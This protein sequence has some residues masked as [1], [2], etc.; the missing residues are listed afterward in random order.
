[1]I[2][3]NYNSPGEIKKTLTELGLSL[4][5]RWGQNFL[6]NRGA[7]KKIIA[8]INPQSTEAIWEIGPGL[9]C[10][11]AELLPLV[12]NLTAFEIDRGFIRFLEKSFECFPNFTL[13]QG[14]VLKTWSNV[15]NEQGTPCTVA[16]N[17]PY[18][19]ASALIGSFA[20]AHFYPK[21]MVFT[22]Q[23]ELA[24]RMTSEP[25]TKNYSSF[26]VICQYAFQIE[27]AFQ[28]K[29]GSFYPAPEVSSV[30]IQLF[31]KENNEQSEVRKLFFRLVKIL[32]S[33]RRKTIKNNLL[34]GFNEFRK[35]I[36]FKAAELEGINIENRSETLSPD[37]VLRFAER[38]LKLYSDF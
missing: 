3:V 6:I 35:E 25:G 8:L 12:K 1:M 33:S 22:V 16:G 37:I 4:K 5:S 31:P 18:S 21:K 26:S 11:T 38:I 14:D 13:K 34:A 23:K 36:L 27:E 20:E 10:M 7:R 17:L 32:F 9:G 15:R 28:L 24:R 30:V 2:R 29:P 19:S